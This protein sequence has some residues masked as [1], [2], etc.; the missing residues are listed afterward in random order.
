MLRQTHKF[1]THK[2]HSREF[3]NQ[4]MICSGYIYIYIY[5]N[6]QVMEIFMI[7]MIII[8]E[9]VILYYSTT[10]FNCSGPDITLCVGFAFW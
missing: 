5:Y 9:I 3:S 4:G 10:L 6:V 8:Q 7:C 2:Y 1:L